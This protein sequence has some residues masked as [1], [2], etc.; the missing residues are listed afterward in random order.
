MCNVVWR[1][2]PRGVFFDESDGV[3][4]PA[5]LCNEICPKGNQQGDVTG[6]DLILAS[7]KVADPVRVRY[8]GR[9]RTCGTLF[10]EMSLPL[11]AFETP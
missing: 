1:N 4:H 6:A 3:W 2:G 10:N 7:E 8:M 9:N 11:G 5:R